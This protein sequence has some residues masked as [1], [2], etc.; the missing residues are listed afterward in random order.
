MSFWEAPK[1]Q[2]NLPDNQKTKEKVEVRREVEE[3]ED[4]SREKKNLENFE[5]EVE[6]ANNN[7]FD[8]IS[9]YPDLVSHIAEE[10]RKNP[11]QNQQ[12]LTLWYIV[13]E[14]KNYL[15]KND[16]PTYEE[17]LP[18]LSEY[19]NL[20]NK[21]KQALKDIDFC[22]CFQSLSE[23]I[24]EAANKLPKKISKRPWDNPFNPERTFYNQDG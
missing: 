8:L 3:K 7:M 19:I 15:E 10:L 21:A 13:W 22:N 16:K 17:T 4:N 24:K 5:Q 6:K 1:T 12:F 18:F 11:S 2:E 20:V 14:I 23:W 9:D